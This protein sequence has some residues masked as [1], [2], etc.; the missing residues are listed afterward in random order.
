[1]LPFEIK[2]NYLQHYTTILNGLS[3]INLDDEYNESDP[4]NYKKSIK[5][6]AIQVINILNSPSKNNQD[7]AIEL[8]T[9]CKQWDII[10][11][12]DATV[13]YPE[14]AEVLIQYGY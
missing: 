11:K 6:Q 1:V 13:L 4:N 3:D 8:V 12:F 10:Y 7:L 9:M 14:L 2:Q 5:Q